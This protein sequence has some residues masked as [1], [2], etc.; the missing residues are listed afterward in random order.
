[1]VASALIYLI[2]IV[3]DFFTGALLV[4]L[5]LQWA[6]AAHRNPLADFV[7]ALTNFAVLPARRVIPGLWG[8][9]LATLLLA[10]LTQ[11]IELFL[12]VQLKG[13]ALGGEPVQAIFVLLLLA[14]F[15]VLRIGVYVVI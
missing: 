15:M 10:W 3:C 1:M 5:F 6:R 11:L 4:R 8:V 13:Y 2:E 7:N 9:D 12:V 14:A